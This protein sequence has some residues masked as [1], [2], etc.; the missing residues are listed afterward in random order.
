[1]AGVAALALSLN[2]SVAFSQVAEDAAVTNAVSEV[3]GTEYVYS[4]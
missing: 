1:M 4:P 3:V 2:A